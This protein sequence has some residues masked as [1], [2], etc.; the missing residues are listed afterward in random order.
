MPRRGKGKRHKYRA[1]IE[2]EAGDVG[3]GEFVK[4]PHSKRAPSRDTTRVLPVGMKTETARFSRNSIY[5]QMGM[6]TP[7]ELQVKGTQ[8]YH[9]YQGVFR[10]FGV[11]VGEHLNMSWLYNQ[12]FFGKGILSRSEPNYGRA[13]LQYDRGVRERE[14]SLEK[15]IQKKKKRIQDQEERKKR[16]GK[17]GKKPGVSRSTP[18]SSSSTP[19]L[20]SPTTDADTSQLEDSL[21]DSMATDLDPTDTRTFSSVDAIDGSSGPARHITR[22]C[23]SLSL[24]EAFFLV[25]GLG[26]LSVSSE[27]GQPMSIEQCWRA[28]CAAKPSFVENYVV[29]LHL[30]SRGWVPKTGLKFAVDWLAYRRGP[31]FYHSSYSILTR[32]AWEDTKEPWSEHDLPISWQYLSS[33]SRMSG[34]A[35]KEAVICYV[36]RPRKVTDEDLTDP[37]CLHQFKV[38]QVLH[39]RWVPAKTRTAPA[40]KMAQSKK[41]S[42]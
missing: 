27:D 4:Q 21:N 7:A 20:N 24:E 17:G 36:T 38:Q 37:S 15:R 9:V 16:R 1:S 11:E 3:F 41:K 6:D 25:H 42:V 26:C 10:G 40:V 23:L 14:T 33:I 12:G 28:F 30:R 8:K 2:L 32:T 35:G 29:Y 34:Q 18:V 39:R 5:R 31:N 13:V 19:V 22:E